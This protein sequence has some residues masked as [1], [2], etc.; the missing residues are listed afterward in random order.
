MG[1]LLG[2]LWP[3]FSWFILTNK[4]DL[5]PCLLWGL[6]CSLRMKE[7]R[8]TQAIIAILATAVLISAQG[9]GGFHVQVHGVLGLVEL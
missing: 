7:E 4:D 8:Q 3:V 1:I 5:L 9:S 6:L 2:S